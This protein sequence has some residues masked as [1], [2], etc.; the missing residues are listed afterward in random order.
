MAGDGLD[1]RLLTDFGAASSTHTIPRLGRTRVVTMGIDV[2][3]PLAWSFFLC[4]DADHT[5]L[6]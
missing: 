2:R 5:T 1:D 4:F 6:W 3:F